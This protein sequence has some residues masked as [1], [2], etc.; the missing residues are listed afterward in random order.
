[1]PH[2]N[3]YTPEYGVAIGRSAGDNLYCVGSGVASNGDQSNIYHFKYPGAVSFTPKN[4]ERLTKTTSDGN[5]AFVLLRGASGYSEIQIDFKA[6]DVD[7]PVITGAPAKDTSYNTAAAYWTE[8]LAAGNAENMWLLL[9]K[10]IVATS[11]SAQ[12]EIT[13]L[14]GVGVF[15]RTPDGDG[16]DH[17]LI[18]TP[19]DFAYV[20]WGD[21]LTDVLSTAPTGGVNHLRETR[22]NMITVHAHLNDANDTF[23]TTYL[24]LS[25]ATENANMLAINGAKTA[26]SSFSTSTGDAVKAAAGTAG[27]Y[28]I[29][30]HE[31]AFVTP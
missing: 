10:R 5:E 14:H 25:S 13:W 1:M 28:D 23:T 11:G 20:P 15:T 26:L 27:H 22:D 3:F 9:Q 6:I 29:L 24:P 19:S 7:A 16:E 31:T 8:S 2:G 12:Y 4:V 30:V 21:A 18:F 17:R